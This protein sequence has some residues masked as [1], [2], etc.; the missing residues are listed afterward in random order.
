MHDAARYALTETITWTAKEPPSIL[1][2]AEKLEAEVRRQLDA[3][4]R[5]SQ[6]ERTK[7]R[8]G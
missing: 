4:A 5:M 7:G 2:E 8:W 1:A 6:Q 3:K